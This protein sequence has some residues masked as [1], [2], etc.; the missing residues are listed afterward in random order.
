MHSFLR[1]SRFYHLLVV[2][3][4]FSHST[5]GSVIPV[6]IYGWPHSGTTITT[7]IIQSYDNVCGMKGAELKAVTSVQFRNAERRGCTHVVVKWPWDMT[8]EIIASK[9]YENYLKIVLVRNPYWIFSSI[10]RRLMLSQKQKLNYTFAI[11]ERSALHFK[12]KSVAKQTNSWETIIY[13]QYEHLFTQIDESLLQISNKFGLHM[14]EHKVRMLKAGNVHDSRS[15]H[16][17]LS[18]KRGLNRSEFHHLRY[19]QIEAKLQNMNQVQKLWLS[20]SQISEI[21]ES[22]I[23]QE[24]GYSLP[25][26]LL[27]CYSVHKHDV[28]CTFGTCMCGFVE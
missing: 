23:V 14:S 1:F 21:S 25:R 17:K 4:Q 12:E 22:K 16:K 8:D 2:T 13:L 28:H 27:D 24:L 20:P 19:S 11:W 9:T 18:K 15:T 26:E 10:N 6:L 7:K 5:I 3:V